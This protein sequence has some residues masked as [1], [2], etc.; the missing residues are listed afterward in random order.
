[1]VG[2]KYT[3]GNIKTDYSVNGLNTVTTAS[4]NP[5]PT[6]FTGSVATGIRQVSTLNFTVGFVINGNKK[7]KDLLGDQ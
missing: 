4:G 2:M 7:W 3:F 6:N 1:M 5:T